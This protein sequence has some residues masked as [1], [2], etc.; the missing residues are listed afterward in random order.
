MRGV[1]MQDVLRGI[2]LILLA[3]IPAYFSVDGFVTGEAQSLSKYVHTPVT[4]AAAM[5]LSLAYGVF[6]AAAIIAALQY[7]SVVARRR[8][9]LTRWAMRVMLVG[10]ALLPLTALVRIAALW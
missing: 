8:A 6:A 5:V 2:L 1:P 4:G 10:I 3:L 9:T 7:F